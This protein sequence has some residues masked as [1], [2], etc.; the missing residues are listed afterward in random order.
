MKLLSLT[1][2]SPA[3]NLAC[4]EALLDT[5]DENGGDEVLRFW[6]PTE[7]FAVVGYANSVTREVDMK[8]CQR[9]GVGVYRRC[10]GGGTVL[11]GPGCLNY[12]LILRIDGHDALGTITGAN[13]HIMKRNRDALRSLLSG[14]VDMQGH[15]D[16]SLDGLKFSGNA[17]RRKRNTLLFHGTFLLQLDLSRVEKLLPMP[18]REPDYRKGRSHE[19]FLTN[20]QLPADAVKQALRRAWSA[21]NVLENPPDCGSLLAEKYS[22]PDWNLKF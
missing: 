2:P 16:L 5:C 3:E 20:L 8:A 12:S 22:R 13:C 6:E 4:D 1:L 9:E 11:Q 10:S 14:T 7:F 18:S 19:Q 21:E 15:T 17:Q